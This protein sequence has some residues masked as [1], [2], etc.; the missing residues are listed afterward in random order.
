MNDSYLM[1]FN[2]V[3]E[4]SR[5]QISFKEANKFQENSRRFKKNQ[6]DLKRL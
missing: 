4:G 2:K 6:E 5:R 3:Q 1:W